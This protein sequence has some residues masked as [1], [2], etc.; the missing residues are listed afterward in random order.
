[1]RIAE[2][3]RRVGTSPRMLRY[4]EDEGLLTPQR[5]LNGYRDYDGVDVQ[6]AEQIVALSEAGLTLSA[7]RTVLPCAAPDGTR[8]RACPRVTPELRRQLDT[9]HDRITALTQ[10]ANAI[11]NYLATLEPR[12]VGTGLEP[13]PAAHDHP[14]SAP[15]ESG[16]AT[17]FCS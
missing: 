7:I 5:G 14:V 13:L 6:T 12:N 15:Q 1:M 10:S 4:Y 11:E 17:A 16:P 3:A 8:L 2:L 9:I